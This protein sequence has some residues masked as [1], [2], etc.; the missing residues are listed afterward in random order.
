MYGEEYDDM[1]VLSAGY[2]VSG[3][4]HSESLSVCAAV[5]TVHCCALGSCSGA[6]HGWMLAGMCRW[7]VCW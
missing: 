2:W 4:A 7:R 1:N 5:H 6:A 3:D